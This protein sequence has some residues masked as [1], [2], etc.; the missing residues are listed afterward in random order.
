M[1]CPPLELL[2]LF[3]LVTHHTAEAVLFGIGR[4]GHRL[5]GGELLQHDRVANLQLRHE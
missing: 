1:L 4:E 2:W 5:G 3:L